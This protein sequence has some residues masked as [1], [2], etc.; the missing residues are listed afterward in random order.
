MPEKANKASKR[1]ISFF[2]MRDFRI[3]LS[4]VT[5]HIFTVN[6][7]LISSYALKT[8]NTLEVASS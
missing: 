8:T 5:L 4:K 2:M 6:N 3:R 7:E 1:G